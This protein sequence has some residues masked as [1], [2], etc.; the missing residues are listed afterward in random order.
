[1]SLGHRLVLLVAAALDPKASG[2]L[3]V[4][5]HQLSDDAK[6]ATPQTTDEDEAVQELGA[7]AR[8]TVR[9]PAADDAERQR[10]RDVLADLEEGQVVSSW[11]DTSTIVWLDSQ[12]WEKRH[13]AMR[14]GERVWRHRAD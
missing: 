8:A 4:N 6:P 7:W 12:A 10:A 14:V 3:E 1:M 13:K 5:L 2:D 11:R 9:D